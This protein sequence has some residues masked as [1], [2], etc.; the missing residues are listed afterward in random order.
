M[1]L[2]TKPKVWTFDSPPRVE[3]ETANTPDVAK[4]QEILS[5]AGFVCRRSGAAPGWFEDH[6]PGDEHFDPSERT[7][8]MVVYYG[9]VR[10]RWIQV[11]PLSAPSDTKASS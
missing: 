4:I 10:E 3:M 8:E 7:T 2:P 9:P 11:G 1:A 6:D 5:K